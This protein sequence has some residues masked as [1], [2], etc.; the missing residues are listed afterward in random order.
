[1]NDTKWIVN[2]QQKFSEGWAEYFQSV[3]P[4]FDLCYDKKVLELAPFI[5]GHTNIIKSYNPSSITLV[6]LNEYAVD[7]LNFYHPDCEIKHDDVYDYL[8]EN[9]DFDVVICCGLLYHLHS[10]IYL[11]ELI[12]NNVSP[13][14]LY[15]ET[16]P[17]PNGSC[18]FAYEQNNELGTKQTKKQRKS[19]NM[20]LMIGEQDIITAMNNMDYK[21]IKLVKGLP[22]PTGEPTFFIFEKL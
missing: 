2:S 19:P 4:Y 16:Y 7:Q 3:R 12:V 1:M 13:K 18:S 21:L 22:K 20:K 15:V 14:Y 9:R 11:L 6:E 17:T 5:G 10:P 8:V